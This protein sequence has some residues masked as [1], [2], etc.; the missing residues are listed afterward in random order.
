MNR[1][2]IIAFL[3]AAGIATMYSCKKDSDVFIPDI[4]ATQGPDTNWYNIIAD[5]MP[6]NILK[7]QLAPGLYLDSFEVNANQVFVTTPSGLTCR[8]P[9]FCCT[10]ANG[11]AI[12]GKVYVE[13]LLVKKKGDMIQADKPTTSNGRLLV[14]GGE[15]FVKLTKN[16]Q[17]LKLAPGKTISLKYSDA[18]ILP[19][20]KVF[21]G[22]ESNAERFNW[23][24]SDS[25]GAIQP[26]IAG[27]NFY[28]L[29]SSQLRWINCDYFYDTTGISRVQVGANLPPQYTNANTTAY[30]VFGNM[31]AVLGMYGNAATKKFQSGKVPVGQQAIVVVISKQGNDYYLGHEGFTTGPQATS[32]AGQQF[33]P[34]TPVKSSLADIKAYLSTL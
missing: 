10:N 13:L 30:L 19:G 7:K 5:S 21:Y 24:P 31:R 1:K 8:F 16:G 25:G 6:V 9:A 20:M 32:P 14:S 22:D 18:P 23:L 15:M 11:Q 17:E 26:V 2:L 27:N 4:T 28:E 33:V 3:L 12:T 29:I 34:L